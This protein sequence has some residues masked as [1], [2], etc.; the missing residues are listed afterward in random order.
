MR[1]GLPSSRSPRRLGFRLSLVL[2]AG[3]LGWGGAQAQEAR[4]G[5]DQLIERARAESPTMAAVR[6]E[7]LAARAGVAT[8]RAYPNPELQ[9]GG[10][11]SSARIAGAPAGS[12]NSIA[13][14]QRIES[15]TLRE[16][17]GRG[18]EAAAQ[19]AGHA[20]QATEQALVANVRIRFFDLLRARELVTAAR[21]DL[22]LAELIRDRVAV[23]VSTGEAPR[24]DLIR[25]ETEAARAR[26]ALAQRQGELAAA[27]A[28][29]RELV[30][31]SL[32]E[33]FDV[34]GDFQASLPPA[35]PGLLGDG[36]I[37]V[38]PELRLAEAERER[39]R[40]Q[41]QVERAN[42]MPGVDL[43]LARERTPDLDT[44]RAGIGVRI[45]LFDRRAGPIEEARQRQARADAIAEQR[46]F[47][48]RQRLEAAWHRYE[49]ARSTVAALENGVL[50]KAE[51]ALGVAEAAYRFGERGILDYLDA[52][53]QYRQ[54][55]I[56][57]IGSRF[58]AFAAQAE[59]EQLASSFF[60]GN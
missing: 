9:A 35:D 60:R 53:R 12:G 17:R 11:N 4:F 50:E 28:R 5:L 36:V 8:A 52:Q 39:A 48:L 44:T 54:L 51:A 34:D 45:P 57:L 18:S 14:T 55:R 2:F 13:I 26:T 23:R 3:A 16:A 24:F 43:F 7:A 40:W 6:A 25:A 27:R 42:L 58:E 33:S 37:A 41:V 59:L 19:A 31:P 49:A 30:A 46:A 22:G 29:L 47:E 1:S 10:S 56:E 32:P 15:P 21:Q 20:V 38:H